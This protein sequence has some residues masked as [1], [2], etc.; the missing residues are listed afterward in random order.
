MSNEIKDLLRE[1]FAKEDLGVIGETNNSGGDYYW[2]PACG[3]SEGISGWCNSMSPLSTIKH[4]PD[5]KLV[6]LYKLAHEEE[7]K[8]GSS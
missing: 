2:C 5:C 1:M 4:K 3:A 6:K 7:G 8:S